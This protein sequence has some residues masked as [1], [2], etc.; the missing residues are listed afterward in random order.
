MVNVFR[1]GRF[2][3]LALTLSKL[4]GNGEVSWFGVNGTTTDIQEMERAREGVAIQLNDVWHNAVIDFGCV[5]SKILW[6]KFKFS[7]VFKVCLVVGY[8]LNGDCKKRDVF[9]NDMEGF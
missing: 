6:V 7:R 8:S 1:K 2:E 3:F 4:K 9:W 5:S